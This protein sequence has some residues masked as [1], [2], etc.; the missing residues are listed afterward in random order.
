MARWG[1]GDPRWIVEERPDAANVNNWHWTEKNASHWSKIKLTSLIEGLQIEDP[2]IGIVT[3]TE[4]NSYEGEAVIH[5]RRGKLIFFYEWILKGYW[6]AKLSDGS[7]D[8]ISGEFDIPNLSEENAAHE[9]DVSFSITKGDKHKSADAVRTLLYAKGRTAIQSKLA[10]YIRELKEEYAQNLIL[11]T[12]GSSQSQGQTGQGQTV[13]TSGGKSVTRINKSGSAATGDQTDTDSNAVNVLTKDLRLEETMKCRAA[14]FY[15]ALTDQQMLSA[16]TQ[17]NA[18]TDSKEGGEFVLFDGN[19]QGKYVELKADS[20]IRQRWR[21]RGW[22]NGH[23]SDVS[24]RIE[25]RTDDTL[26]TLEQKSIPISDF[27]RTENGWRRFYF[28]S[29]K[30]TFGFGSILF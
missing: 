4:S 2:A 26:V 12:K 27:E 28:D 8:E 24:I 5:N 29:I 25:Q 3:V 11:P 9:V 19:V 6:S 7:A 10:D 18:V 17:S 15:R 20:L 1:E 13:N 21:F 16:F 14:E 23:Y 22:P 30:R